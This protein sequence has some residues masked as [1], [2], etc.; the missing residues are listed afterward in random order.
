VWILEH[1]ALFAVGTIC[2]YPDDVPLHLGITGP[3]ALQCLNYGYKNGLADAPL[4]KQ[5]AMAYLEQGK[6]HDAITTL[7]AAVAASPLP[8]A[9]LH[10]AL[11]EALL[12]CNEL[13]AAK[14]QWAVAEGLA[15][16]DG[17][18]IRLAIAA[19]EAR[20]CRH[21]SRSPPS[22]AAALPVSAGV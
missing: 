21:P 13:T 2:D 7:R 8:D 15:P 18:A 17:A 4:L 6:Y 16:G 9:D 5:V 10:V 22:A 12:A 14:A 19:I 11:G 20:L 1:S 3:V